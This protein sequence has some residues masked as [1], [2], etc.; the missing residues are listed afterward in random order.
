MSWMSRDAGWFINLLVPMN[1]KEEKPIQFDIAN[2]V[3]R[4]NY[5]LVSKR[6]HGQSHSF[7]SKLVDV[8]FPNTQWMYGIFFPHIWVVLGVNVGKYTMVKKTARWPLRLSPPSVKFRTFVGEKKHVCWKVQ[9]ED[10]TI[11]CTKLQICFHNTY[12]ISTNKKSFLR[13]VQA[14]IIRPFQ[15]TD[16]WW[17]L[18][19]FATRL[20]SVNHL[21]VRPC[22]SF[23]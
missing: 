12:R 19:I 11:T 20:G 18:D 3:I 17:Y 22:R 6:S 15:D 13:T 9:W 16:I 1:P 23:L 8:L 4:K 21:S 7:V 14:A 10:R 5:L 2:M